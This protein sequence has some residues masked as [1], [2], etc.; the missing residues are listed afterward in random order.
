[1][2]FLAL[3]NM[4][5]LLRASPKGSPSVKVTLPVSMSYKETIL[6]T[7]LTFLSLNLT[8]KP[9]TLGLPSPFFIVK[10]TS[11][12][13]PFSVATSTVTSKPFILNFFI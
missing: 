9:I 4:V 11:A 1:M 5:V 3:L 7:S 12:R 8:S 10:V 6:E 13:P 2:A